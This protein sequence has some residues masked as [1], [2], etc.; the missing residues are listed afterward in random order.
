MSKPVSE[1]TNRELAMALQNLARLVL[2]GGGDHL[3][4]DEAAARLKA[5]EEITE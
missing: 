2:N 1:W 3:F 4:L 5:Y